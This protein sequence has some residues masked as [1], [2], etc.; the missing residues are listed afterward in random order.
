MQHSN[1]TFRPKLRV[2][3]LAVTSILSVIV[4]QSVQA[5]DKVTVSE[6]NGFINDNVTDMDEIG[7]AHV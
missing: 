5:E 2:L 7:R 6:P 3:T 4:N 1:K